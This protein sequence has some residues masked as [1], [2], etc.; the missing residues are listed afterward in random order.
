MAVVLAIA[1][2]IIERLIDADRYLPMAT[3][4]VEKA[5]SLPVSAKHIDIALFPT[6]S[7]P[8][9]EVD[10][11]DAEFNAHCES[12]SA[13]VKL[14]S[15]VRGKL[16]VTDVTVSG[17]T[18]RLPETL[19]KTSERIR[20]IGPKDPKQD[21]AG[22]APRLS[23]SRVS[24]EDVRV[25]VG[26][27][28]DPVAEGSAIISN[29]LSDAI[30]I[31]ADL[32]TPRLGQDAHLAADVTL[33]RG[34]E[35][36]VGV[37][38]T[39]KATSIET[40]TFIPGDAIPDGTATLTATLDRTGP[41]TY[42]VDITGDATPN[43]YEG[44]DL[45]PLVGA[46]TAKAWWDD[47]TFTIND[48]HWKASGTELTGDV[49]VNL[50]ASV[51]AN[52]VS[53]TINASGLKALFAF[54]PPGQFNVKTDSDAAFQ[55]TNVLF[56]VS[57]E[58]ELRLA[59]GAAVFQGINLLVEGD[60]PAVGAISGSFSVQEN[61]IV[62]DKFIG[63]GVALSGS[64]RPDLKTGTTLFDLAGEADV[65]QERLKG[66]GGMPAFSDAGG[67]LVLKRVRGTF[68]PGEGVPAD[69]SIEGS[70][71]KA[72]LGIASESWTDRLDPLEVTFAAGVNDIETEASAQSEMLGSVQSTGLYHFAKR[73]WEGSVTGDIAD[74]QLPWL[75]QPS[76]KAVAPGILGAFGASQIDMTV[77]L[78][79]EKEKSLRVAFARRGDPVLKGDVMM[80]QQADGMGIGPINVSA[81]VPGNAIQAVL[82]TDVSVSGTIPFVFAFSPEKKQFQAT[83]DLTQP[84]VLA[85][86]YADKASGMPASV[87][88]IGDAPPGAW[89]AKTIEVKCAA[90]SF[91]GKPVDGRFVVDALD[92][93][94]G[95]ISE[96]LPGG[97]KS[98]G[99]VTGSFAAQPTDMK[100]ALHDVG[101][102]FTEG[103]AIDSMNGSL[104][105]IGDTF[106]CK[107]LTI[108]GADS[109]CVVDATMQGN[110]IQGTITGNQF[111]MNAVLSALD[112]SKKARAE[113]AAKEP[114][115]VTPGDESAGL[116]GR[117]TV[118][119]KQLHY[120]RADLDNMEAVI[121]FAKNGYRIDPLRIQ[122]YG[123][124]LTGV[125]ASAPIA[126][127]QA[128]AL[129]M[130]LLIDR[131]DARMLEDL[132]AA[133]PRGLTGALS[134]SVALQMP[135]VEG[136]SPIHGANGIVTFTGEN[137][138]FGKL[139]IAS[140]IVTVLRTTEIT[141]L[142]IPSLKDEGLAYDKCMGEFVFTNGVMALKTMK[143]E[144]PSYIIQVGGTIDFPNN[145]TNLEVHVNILE[146][147][148]GAADLI[149]GGK[150]VTKLLREGGGLRIRLTGPIDNPTPTYDF[151]GNVTGIAKEVLKAT[152]GGTNA[153]KDELVK[154]A[155]EVLKGLLQGR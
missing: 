71:T 47:G 122:P 53:A 123:G 117:F 60:K 46:Y 79:T 121:T 91:V 31:D 33:A 98:R 62:I 83:I 126:G 27:A 1:W 75:K 6:P 21:A 65:T 137:G 101:L 19:A 131:V 145:M 32:D 140:K 20:A 128:T 54:Q 135:L 29:P 127:T 50:D 36:G 45:T 104:S 120:A 81:T 112:A 76:A 142:R 141:R 48:I 41:K 68:K 138:S 85:G 99:R 2:P 34:Q 52:V 10:V 139:G 149:P 7:A 152:E 96:M 133:E 102:N 69:L 134:G 22:A 107:G 97:L 125:V 95:S 55:A 64:L 9:L 4:A 66:I 105:Y 155:S 113:S 61:T 80:L 40:A 115:P 124:T 151:K 144:S 14:R 28:T 12:V 44:V 5:T 92:I 88:V 129:G 24:V 70:L 23:V 100:L 18:V 57:P 89:A 150:E 136:V 13:Y 94:M 17:V 56:G 67:R 114:P 109:D 118:S 37:R 30:A 58:K 84:R 16:D 116:E 39:V 77:S 143:V 15:L 93:D 8:V 78:P 106:A 119:V 110:R 43:T 11:G 72:R 103:A 132:L 108:R 148:L 42:L 26:A 38:G 49:T 51:A 82:P 63:E 90:E 73:V 130:E 146:T 25:F 35:F 86:G 147:V 153:V 3:K 111:D 59:S 154:G 87:V 74:V